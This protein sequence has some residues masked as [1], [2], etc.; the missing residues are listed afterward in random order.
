MNKV[1]ASFSKLLTVIQTIVKTIISSIGPILRSASK[2]ISKFLNGTV[3]LKFITHPAVRWGLLALAALYLV[4]GGLASW[5]V[6]QVKSESA[7]IRRILAIYPL[8]AVL[9]PQ[10]VILVKDYLHQ[11]KY[12][13]HF[14]DKTKQVLPADQELRSQ[15]LNQMIETRLLLRTAAGQN[16]RIVKADIDAAYQKIADENGGPEEL[17][18]LLTDLYGMNESEFRLLIRDQLLREKVRKEL[19]VQVKAQHILIRDEK[20]AREILEQAKKEPAKFDELVKQYTEDTGT[21]DKNG[22]LGFF[23]RGV[24][25]KPVEDA[26]FALSKGEIGP[27]IVKSE[28]GF[29][30]IKVTDRKGTVDKTYQQYIDELQK[31]RKAWIILK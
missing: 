11:L 4:I 19:L 10:D 18:K 17:Q 7:N 25:A 29:H 30:I 28:F 22:D 21:R 23:G 31:K 12:I 24:M 14:A 20:K 5:K 6:Y 13:R 16:I 26:A 15:L 9:M 8:P 27:D 1:V 2:R 3:N